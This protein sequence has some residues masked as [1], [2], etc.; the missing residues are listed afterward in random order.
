MGTKSLILTIYSC[1]LR[2]LIGLSVGWSG[3][4]SLYIYITTLTLGLVTYSEK[5][6]SGKVQKK[7]ESNRFLQFLLFLQFLSI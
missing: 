5:Q 2:I 3:S 1:I 6:D 7:N 4:S